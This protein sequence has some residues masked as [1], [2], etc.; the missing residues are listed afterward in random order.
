MLPDEK[1]STYNKTELGSRYQWDFGDDTYSS[2][3]APEH[4]YTELGTYDV[5]LI[6][7]TNQG[8]ADTLTLP[9]A[10]SVEGEG[11]IEFPDAFMPE[12]G[13][14]NGGYW[15]E[16]DW[17]N[18]FIF[19][20]YAKGIVDYSLE[21]YNRWG[22]LVFETENLYQGWDG[23]VDSKLANQEV[24]VW[25]AKGTFT[26]GQKFVKAGDVT[27]LHAPREPGR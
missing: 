5:T 3:Q 10:V 13:G 4:Q 21:I 22:E 6:S 27:V 1:I 8:C 23:Y 11:F 25:R 15:S 16:N 7:W 24:Y 14:P 20:P 17:N 12:L 9:D 2:L 19:R 18:P 26:N